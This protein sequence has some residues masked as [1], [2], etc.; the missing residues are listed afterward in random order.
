M[1]FINII[2][3]HTESQVDKILFTLTSDDVI[4]IENVYSNFDFVEYTNDDG[5]ECM[6]CIMSE[7][8]MSILSKCYRKYGVKFRFVDLS[9]DVLFDNLFNISFKNKYGFSS[10]QKISKL[11]LKF[12]KLNTTP[13][14]ILDKI[15]EKGI[16]SLTKFDKSILEKV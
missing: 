11:I 3:N 1:R 14:V 16:Q 10:K 6:F 15:L 2:T 4:Y 12:K 9:K 5:K 13:D 8:D 7:S